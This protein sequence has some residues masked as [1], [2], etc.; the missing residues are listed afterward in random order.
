MSSKLCFPKRLAI[1]SSL[2]F[3]VGISVVSFSSLSSSANKTTSSRAAVNKSP[4]GLYQQ[5]CCQKAENEMVE[6]E[7]GK[8]FD[9]ESSY[10]CTDPLTKCSTLNSKANAYK[11]L[12]LEDVCGTEDETPCCN[13]G[14]CKGRSDMVC[15]RGEKYQNPWYGSAYNVSPHRNKQKSPGI[16]RSGNIQSAITPKQG[17]PTCGVRD[18]VCCP[19]NK[20]DDIDDVCVFKNP[21]S[22]I[23]SASDVSFVCKNNSEIMLKL[24]TDVESMPSLSEI[25]D[26]MSIPTALFRANGGIPTPLFLYITADTNVV[27]NETNS[28]GAPYIKVDN[29][30]FSFACNYKSDADYTPISSDNYFSDDH[31]IICEYN[32]EDI[33]K[34]IIVA[35]RLDIYGQNHFIKEIKKQ[36]T[37]IP[38]SG[39]LLAATPSPTQPPPS[40]GVTCTKGQVLCGNRDQFACGEGS[41]YC[42]HAGFSVG[43]DNKCK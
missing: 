38:Y 41:V 31:T 32:Q 29:R 12:K 5:Q 14:T 39:S 15:I 13:D 1:I 6:Y 8:Y 36:V 2:L 26:G 16:C 35:V 42:C 27:P 21:N 34:Q 40:S 10:Y 7:Y 11:C 20:C 17:D 19:V 37:L 3:F 24:Y 9:E 23:I 18:G 33:N 25:V 4:C 22:S 30:A 43:T 28:L